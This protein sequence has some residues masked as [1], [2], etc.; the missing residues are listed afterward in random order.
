MS[1]LLRHGRPNGHSTRAARSQNLSAA[2]RGMRRQGTD[3]KGGQVRRPSLAQ[4]QIR[5]SLFSTLYRGGISA[6]Q[7]LNYLLGRLAGCDHA[8]LAFWA[9]RSRGRRWRR[10]IYVNHA[11]IYARRGKKFPDVGFTLDSSRAIANQICQKTAPK[12]A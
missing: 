5:P 1:R 9:L 3:T 10:V 12:A 7:T 4:I 11:D 6:S 8:H 2:V